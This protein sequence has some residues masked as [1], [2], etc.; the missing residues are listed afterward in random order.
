MSDHQQRAA[1]EAWVS[2]APYERPTERYPAGAEE[3]V[4]PGQYR[5]YPVQLAWEAWQ[6]G[7]A[8]ATRDEKPQA[9]GREVA[10]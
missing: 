5:D 9:D 4:W 8:A 3:C 10:E 6:A 2:G 1:F 7:E